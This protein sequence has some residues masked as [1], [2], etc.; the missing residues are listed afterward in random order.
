[1]K[2]HGVLRHADLGTGVWFL[3]TGDGEKIALVGDV[4]RGLAGKQVEVKGKDVDAMGIGMVGD[5]AVEVSS[6]RAR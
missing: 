4:P 5:R 3:E 2:L 6:I 1:M